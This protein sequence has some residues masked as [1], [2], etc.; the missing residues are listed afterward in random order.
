MD[1]LPRLASVFI[2][3]VIAPSAL[4]V[5]PAFKMTEHYH[6]KG[7]LFELLLL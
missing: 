4:A 5:Y 2:I 6:Q 7:G 1:I 3:A